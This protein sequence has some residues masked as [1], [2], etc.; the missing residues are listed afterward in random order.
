MVSFVNITH[1]SRQQ[2]QGKLKEF[3][4][5]EV[6]GTLLFID[7]LERYIFQFASGY[8]FVTLSLYVL[9]CGIEW[10]SA[11][12]PCFNQPHGGGGVKGEFDKGLPF[13][14]FSNFFR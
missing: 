13:L 12:P 9:G 5:Y 14:P 2:F 6:L 7:T 8:H 1:L 10:G 11:T 4:F 3:L